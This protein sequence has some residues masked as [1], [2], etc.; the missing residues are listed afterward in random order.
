MV[1]LTE[2]AYTIINGHLELVPW[3]VP[4]DYETPD[5]L[6]M[7]IWRT[8][9]KNYA[10]RAR[11]LMWCG[12]GTD[13]C[14]VPMHWNYQTRFFKTKEVALMWINNEFTKSPDRLVSLRRCGKPERLVSDTKEHHKV[15]SWKTTE[16]KFFG[17]NKTL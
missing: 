12:D 4:I 14:N 1:A 15:E 5:D 13:D 11:Y 17:W 16:W 2:A 9:E 6:Y 3:E 7:V 10:S 8:W